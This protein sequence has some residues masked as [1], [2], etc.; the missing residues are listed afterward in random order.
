MRKLGV[1]QYNPSTRGWLLRS[2]SKALRAA[3]GYRDGVVTGKMAL[4]AA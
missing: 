2:A 4:Q 1:M 3:K